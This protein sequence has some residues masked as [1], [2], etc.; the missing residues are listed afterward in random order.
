[1]VGSSLPPASSFQGYPTSW[2]KYS[3]VDKDSGGVGVSLPCTCSQDPLE[4]GMEPVW[5]VK[6]QVSLSHCCL[7]L[8]HYLSL[9]LASLS[10][11]VT[12]SLSLTLLPSLPPA[13]ARPGPGHGVTGRQ[14]ACCL[15]SA[16]TG[17]G[18]SQAAVQESS[19]RPAPAT[20]HKLPPAS[21]PQ[22]ILS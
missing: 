19:S 1:M 8:T 14:D 18:P 6:C 4:S 15:F 2:L 10:L 3:G 7:S 17:R 20:R 22:H 21:P 16:L 13:L 9:S 11:L 5:R 12:I